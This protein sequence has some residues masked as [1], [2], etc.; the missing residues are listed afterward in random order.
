MHERYRE[1]CAAASIGEAAPEELAELEM[2]LSHCGRCRQLYSDF[3]NIAAHQYSQRENLDELSSAEINRLLGFD[4]M[5]EKFQAAAAGQEIP[6]RQP[7]L[8]RS[9]RVGTSRA[10]VW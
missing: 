6:F 7:P 1:L 2:H 9:A 4:G 5:R 8:A 3:L 10:Q